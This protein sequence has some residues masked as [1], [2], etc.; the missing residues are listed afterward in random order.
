MPIHNVF[1]ALTDPPAD[2][3]DTVIA[4][5]YH[6][7]DT[8]DIADIV[9]TMLIHNTFIVLTDPP[10]DSADIEPTLPTLPRLS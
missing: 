2:T 3:A 6:P 8:V 5:N 4:L 7:A 1:I 10:A 9:P